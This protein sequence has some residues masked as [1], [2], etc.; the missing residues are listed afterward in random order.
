MT[1][2]GPA[3]REEP[4]ATNRGPKSQKA[5]RTVSN[6]GTFAKNIL[7]QCGPVWFF[8]IREGRRLRYVVERGDRS[9]SYGLLF[10]AEGKFSRLVREQGAK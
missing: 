10:Q 3:G 4:P 9:W 8:E 2:A 5:D 1:R 6:S 7:K